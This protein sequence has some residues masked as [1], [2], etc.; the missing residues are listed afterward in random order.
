MHVVQ[1]LTHFDLQL[2]SASRQLLMQPGLVHAAAQVER[3]VKHSAEHALA[4]EKHV[5]VAP[6]ASAGVVSAASATLV[7]DDTFASLVTVGV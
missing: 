4:D 1:S 6:H 5:A 7:S 2:F 3:F